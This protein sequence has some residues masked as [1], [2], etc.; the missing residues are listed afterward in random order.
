[1]S[2][3]KKMALVLA[4]V[5]LTTGLA[6]GVG[7]ATAAPASKQSAVAEC[8]VRSDGKLWCGNRVGARGYQHRSYASGI[9]GQLNTSFSWFACW[10]YGDTHAGGNDIWY[11]TQLDNG[12][13]GNVPA[14]D[15]YTPTDPWGGLRMC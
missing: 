5:A 2:V 4:A 9:R 3:R 14:V 8:G 11:W 12:Q 13:W 7:P 15:V 10:G 6:T 1:M